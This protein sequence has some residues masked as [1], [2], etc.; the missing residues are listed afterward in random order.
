MISSYFI[1]L[2]LHILPAAAQV[3]EQVIR[4]TCVFTFAGIAEQNGESPD[5]ST[6]LYGILAGEIAS[7]VFCFIA[8]IF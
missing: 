4:I 6:A 1:G 3:I 7:S 5:A 2:E 8:V